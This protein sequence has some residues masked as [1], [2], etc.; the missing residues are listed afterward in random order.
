MFALTVLEG[1]PG[2]WNCRIYAPGFLDYPV[3]SSSENLLALLVSSILRSLR[4]PTVFLCFLQPSLILSR[5]SCG[6]PYLLVVCIPVYCKCCPFVLDLLLV[7][8][9]AF[10]WRFKENQNP[11]LS[12]NPL[13]NININS[14]INSF[15]SFYIC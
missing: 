14:K 1:S 12:Q 13:S 10:K 6:F 3:V 11:K 7:A 5:F 8:L 2:S 9:S 15:F 4:S